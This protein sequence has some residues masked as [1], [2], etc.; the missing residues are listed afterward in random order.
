MVQSQVTQCKLTH[1]MIIALGPAHCVMWASFHR[2]S[3][4]YNVISLILQYKL[5]KYHFLCYK[6]DTPKICVL[7]K[8]APNH[9]TCRILHTCTTLI[10]CKLCVLKTSHQTVAASIAR[11]SCRQNTQTEVIFDVIISVIHF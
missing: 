4:I 2:V 1:K 5:L 6:S 7:L 9:R 8:I 3:R 11:F 10:E